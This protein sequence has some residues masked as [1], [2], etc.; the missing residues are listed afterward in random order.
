MILGCRD[1]AWDKQA[2]YFWPKCALY[3]CRQSKNFQKMQKSLEILCY[4]CTKNYEYM[5]GSRVIEIG[6]RQTN[7]SFLA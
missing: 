6:L 7:K 2:G 5:F 3:S 1:M 4:I